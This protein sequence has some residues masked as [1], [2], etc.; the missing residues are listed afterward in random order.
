[1]SD[2][3]AKVKTSTL[4][5]SKVM[6]IALQQG[7]KSQTRRPVKGAHYGAIDI[8]G[9]AFDAGDQ[10]W[11]WYDSKESSL[12][13][14]SFA[15]PYGVLG[16]RLRFVTGW[17]VE[18]KFDKVRPTDLPADARVFTWFSGAKKP[19]WCGR[20]RMGRHL[21]GAWRTLYSAVATLKQVRVVRV[22]EIAEQDAEAVGIRAFTKDD[23]VFKYWCCDPADDYPPKELR[24]TWQEMPRTRREAAKALYIAVYGQE[25][26]DRNDWVW[27]LDFG[28][29][30]YGVK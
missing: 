18:K 1:M 16:D 24:M 20:M 8:A 15:C 10:R 17:A 22:Q 14:K 28:C 6:A 12:G 4:T 27:A 11:F 7:H 29:V 5:L 2:T 13:L 23:R 25:A 9:A 3:V 26:W 30:E 19:E 21:P